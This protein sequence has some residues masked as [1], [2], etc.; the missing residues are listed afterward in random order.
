MGEMRKV[1]KILIRKPE[2]KRSLGRCRYRWDDNIR[3]DLTGWE[4]VNWIHL[5]E[6]RDEGQVLVNMVMNL[7]LP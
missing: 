3:M 5:A 4:V 7:Q 2:G 6:D 1:Y